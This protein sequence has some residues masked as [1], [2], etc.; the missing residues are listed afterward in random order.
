MIRERLIPAGLAILVPREHHRLRVMK[1]AF[2]QRLYDAD[3]LFRL[4]AFLS[5]TYRSRRDSNLV[6]R[7]LPA[8]AAPSPSHLML[9][10]RPRDL[11]AVRI[12]SSLFLF[13]P[14][15]WRDVLCEV[16]SS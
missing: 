16:V 6:S 3:H 7:M 8:G 9:H 15:T 4:A 12:V 14:S 10:A 5:P 2:F 1:R 13:V 11:L